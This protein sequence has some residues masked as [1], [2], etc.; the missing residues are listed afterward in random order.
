MIIIRFDSNNLFYLF[1]FF[2]LFS[3][4]LVS[5]FFILNE[6]ET[7]S[8]RWTENEIEKVKRAHLIILSF[9]VL[10]GNQTSLFN[11][12]S[13][14]FVVVVRFEWANIGKLSLMLLFKHLKQKCVLLFL[15]LFPLFGR[16]LKRT[17]ALQ[18]IESILTSQ[19]TKKGR[20]PNAN[21]VDIEE[22]NAYIF[23]HQLLMPQWC[24]LVSIMLNKIF[25]D[26]KDKG[27][28]KKINK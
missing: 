11:F 23:V 2:F 8:Y 28:K 4:L 10:N 3:S 1:Y 5:S 9:N 19:T 20:K 21:N 14:Q 7:S 27:G 18:F 22:Q 26:L 13:T 6:D 17:Y 12:S 15:G 16:Y 25:N 24:Y